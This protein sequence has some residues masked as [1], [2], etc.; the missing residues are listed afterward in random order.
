MVRTGKIRDLL[1]QLSQVLYVFGLG[2]PFM[3]FFSVRVTGWLLG[4]ASASQGLWET[5]VWLVACETGL[6]LGCAYAT[7]TWILTMRFFLTRE[8]I[9]AHLTEHYVPVI[10]DAVLKIF[11]FVYAKP[12]GAGAQA[13]GDPL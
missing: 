9:E 13:P 8:R 10:S 1:I 2:V 3:Y 12:A 5:A 7:L 4:S 6:L 11:D